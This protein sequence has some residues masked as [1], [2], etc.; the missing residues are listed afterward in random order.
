MVAPA[1]RVP[2]DEAGD[3]I[4]KDP[5]R[6][7]Q[8]AIRL[9]IDEGEA[10]QRAVRWTD[11][12]RN[13][14]GSV[15]RALLWFLEHGLELPARAGGGPV[16]W[17]RPRHSTIREFV[18]NPAYGGA[19]AC[20]RTG[21]SV[22]CDGAVAKARPRRKPREEWLAREPGA[23]EGHVDRDRPD[24][25]AGAI[26]TMGGRRRAGCW[27]P[28]GPEAR[29]RAPGGHPALPPLRPEAH[30]PAHRGQARHPAA[31]ACLRGRLDY[32]EPECIAFGGLR[33]CDVVE[34]APTAV[35]QP[36]AVEAARAAEAQ[37][38]ARRDEA[39]E[40]REALVRDLEAARLT[41]RTAP[42]AST[43]PPTRR[44]DWWPASSRPAWCRALE[45]VA[46]A[47][48]RALERVAAALRRIAEHDAAVA[49]HA[50]IAPVR[51]D[52]LAGDLRA[53]WGAPTT[54]AR[55][56]KR[57]V[58]T[59]VREAI[60]DVDEAAAEIVLTLHWVGGAHDPASAAS[61]P[62]PARAARAARPPTSWRRC[63]PWR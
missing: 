15:R 62:A 13:E 18:A 14:L 3:R 36:A 48:R 63:A 26:R 61:A 49:P 41:L 20:G 47:L 53:V 35:V 55:L 43:T 2:R 51:F 7:V 33:A 27:D 44:T 46:A 24:P 11:R 30:R 16:V 50:T 9:A 38:A 59:V 4:E 37:A 5:D 58:R 45:R 29:L 23:H 56:R 25:D 28:R 42:S 31:H 6:R 1:A 32:G 40:A 17:R 57:I 8:A 12:P 52:A 39:R 34:A 21:V 10:G 22:A 54:D 19:Y 60:G